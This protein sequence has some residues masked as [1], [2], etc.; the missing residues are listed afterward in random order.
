MRSPDDLKQPAYAGVFNPRVPGSTVGVGCRGLAATAERRVVR[1]K[2]A[3]ETEDFIIEDVIVD[4]AKLSEVELAI[5]LS[6]V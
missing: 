1:P 2:M 6:L 3:D 4:G 5:R